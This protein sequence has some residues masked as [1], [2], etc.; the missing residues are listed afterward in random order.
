MTIRNTRE[1]T[2]IVLAK[3]NKQ[4]EK[5]GV[6]LELESRYDYYA[7]DMYKIGD[8]HTMLKS[9]AHGLKLKEVNMILSALWTVN[10]YHLNPN[11]LKGE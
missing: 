1:Q 10:F 3:V 9:L 2:K 5:T 7:L 8:K 6:K 4:L 11:E